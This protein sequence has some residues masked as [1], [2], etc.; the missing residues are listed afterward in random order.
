MGS[1]DTGAARLPAGVRIRDLPQRD[2]DR[3]SL[4]EL[5]STTLGDARPAR[6]TVAVKGLPRNV[7]VEIEAV[8]LVG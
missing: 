4:A 3:G 1:S 5:T 8:A 7:L 2:D 6:S